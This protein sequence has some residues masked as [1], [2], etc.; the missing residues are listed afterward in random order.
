[1]WKRVGSGFWRGTHLNLPVHLPTYLSACLTYPSES[2]VEK[3][4]EIGHE[5]SLRRVLWS[6]FG[7]KLPQRT[8][9]EKKAKHFGKTNGAV[10][11]SEG[12]QK[13]I[14]HGLSERYSFSHSCLFR[15]P[16]APLG[17]LSLRTEARTA[18]GLINEVC[19]SGKIISVARELFNWE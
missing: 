9:T 16:S 2:W 17:F 11:K 8:G 6:S 18:T 5:F 14:S 4:V 1:M 12:S 3:T 10:E 15:S 7:R 19:S 13:Q